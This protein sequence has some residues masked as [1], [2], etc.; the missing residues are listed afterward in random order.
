MI[1]R[2]LNHM[3]YNYSTLDFSLLGFREA[4]KKM[5]EN[6]C[7]KVSDGLSTPCKA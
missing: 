3:Q 7:Q 2:Y 1:H 5:E 4:T 6:E